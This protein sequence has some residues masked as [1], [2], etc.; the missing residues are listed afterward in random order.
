MD[1]KRLGWGGVEPPT[2]R[3]QGSGYESA[4]PRPASVT[5]IAAL[6]RTPLNGDER[7]RMR[8]KMSPSLAFVTRPS[9]I[10]Y[11]TQ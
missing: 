4:K 2:F 3:I 5:C 11:L 10:A 7:I 8:P 6:T 1:T 9:M